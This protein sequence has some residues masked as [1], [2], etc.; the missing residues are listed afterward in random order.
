MMV[1]LTPGGNKEGKKKKKEKPGLLTRALRSRASRKQSVPDGDST[2]SSG[3][4]RR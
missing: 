2:E 4:H 1:E 3:R